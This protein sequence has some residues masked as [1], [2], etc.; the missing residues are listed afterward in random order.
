MIRLTEQSELY[1]NMQT[2]KEWS[3]LYQRWCIE[4]RAL[5]CDERLST[6]YDDIKCEGW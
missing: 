6:L 3:A 5:G 4:G 2:L 1:V